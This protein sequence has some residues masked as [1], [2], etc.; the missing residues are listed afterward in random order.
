MLRLAEAGIR[1]VEV[2]VRQRDRTIP[3]SA[4]RFW[5]VR[6]DKTMI[7]PEPQARLRTDQ[8]ER[9]AVA[10]DRSDEPGSLAVPIVVIVASAKLSLTRGGP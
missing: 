10:P 4:A 3:A 1:Q 2:A 7:E 5:N 9:Q 6:I 8:T